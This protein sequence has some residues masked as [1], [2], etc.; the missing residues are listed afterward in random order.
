MATV[1]LGIFWRNRE[2]PI[3]KANNRILSY[4]LLISIALCFMDTLLFIGRPSQVC[5][6]LRQAAFGVVFTVSISSVLAKTLTVIIAFK[7][8][9]PG[10]RVKKLLGSRISIILVFLCSLGEILL[11]VL[12]IMLY[13]P[14]LD[15]DTEMDTILLFCNQGS[16]TFFFLNIGYIGILALICLG[17][18]FLAKDFP[19]RFNEAKNISFSILIFCSVWVTFVPT[20]LSVKGKNMVAVEVFAILTSS[21]GLMSFIF[22]PKCYFIYI[23]NKQSI[24]R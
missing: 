14:Y 11:S 1:I 15:V 13:P 21:A 3:V 6:L 19:D 5:C 22:L 12:W 18:A 17:A 7:A 20:Y 23:S 16:P 4:I 24:R 2:T 8:T 10:S 9:Q